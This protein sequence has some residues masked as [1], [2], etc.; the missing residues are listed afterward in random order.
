MA[1]PRRWKNRQISV[2][3][4]KI[5]LVFFP[6]RRCGWDLFSTQDNIFVR[7]MRQKLAKSVDNCNSY[8]WRQED[9]LD[10]FGLFFLRS[11]KSFFNACR[12]PLWC[13]ERWSVIIF[14]HCLARMGE[15]LVGKVEFWFFD[16]RRFEKW[17]FW[18]T[19]GAVFCRLPGGWDLL[20]RL[21]YIV[22]RIMRQQ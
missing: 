22:A 21:D 11:I 12:M 1:G 20:S 6:R 19:S 7:V 5:F 10:I 8:A 2:L 18:K 9:F 16:G 4:R 13:I 3:L 17:Y 14:W 15:F